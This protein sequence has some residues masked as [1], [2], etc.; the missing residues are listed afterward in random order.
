[1]KNYVPTLFMMDL[2]A[3]YG[4]NK[5]IKM[6]KSTKSNFYNNYISS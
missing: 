1:M 4:R 3:E 5:I 2:G 6:K